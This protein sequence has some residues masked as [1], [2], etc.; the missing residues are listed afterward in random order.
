MVKPG[1]GRSKNTILVSNLLLLLDFLHPDTSFCKS[2]NLL[3]HHLGAAKL[4]FR[5][6]L[7]ADGKLGKK[8][9]E[10]AR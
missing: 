10:G 4:R 9:K 7:P 1:R 2:R 3:G 6:G 8:T 5:Y